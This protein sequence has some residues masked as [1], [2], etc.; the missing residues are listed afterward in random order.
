MGDLL[1]SDHLKSL[2]A[3][4]L[5]SLGR[6]FA[7]FHLL[8][9]AEDHIVKSVAKLSQMGGMIGMEQLSRLLAVYVCSLGEE[10]EV[11]E[12]P[13]RGFVVYD[14]DKDRNTIAT[15]I[16]KRLLDKIDTADFQSDKL[17]AKSYLEVVLNATVHIIDLISISKYF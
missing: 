13:S 2:N 11:V 6:L 5:L 16:E 12:D 15:G 8:D 9:D 17:Q 10:T 14:E 4:H 7:Q 1:S 3:I